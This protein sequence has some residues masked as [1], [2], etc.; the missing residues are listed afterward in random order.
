MYLDQW[1]Y[2]NTHFWH[3]LSE[4]TYSQSQFSSPTFN[5]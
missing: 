3:C 5:R 4:A 2:P 1:A